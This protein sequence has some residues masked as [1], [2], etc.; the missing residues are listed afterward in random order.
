MS[1][2]SDMTYEKPKDINMPYS[3]ELERPAVFTESGQLMF[4]EI[5][6]NAGRLLTA[7]GAVRLH[8]L[9]KGVPGDSWLMLACVDRLVELNEIREITPAGSVAGQHRVFV[10]A[11]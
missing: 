3:Y 10:R 5:R 7:A 2:L 11:R 1:V 6:D 9:I 4:L 8:E